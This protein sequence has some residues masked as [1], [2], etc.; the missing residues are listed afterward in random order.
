MKILSLNKVEKLKLIGQSIRA[1]T[2]VFGTSLI[3]SEG[4]PYVTIS[5]LAIGAIANEVVSFLKERENK[6]MTDLTIVDNPDEAK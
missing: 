1:A 3:L 6:A 2:G 4:H 5:I